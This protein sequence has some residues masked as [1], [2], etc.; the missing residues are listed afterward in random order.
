MSN[1]YS[2]FYYVLTN[3]SPFLLTFYTLF[4]T[5]NSTLEKLLPG[6]VD[7]AIELVLGSQGPEV[8]KDIPASEINVPQGYELIYDES[9][10]Y[11]YQ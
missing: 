7:G 8:S 10:G 11:K 9:T 3:N 4:T 6:V 2:I 1:Q 5:A